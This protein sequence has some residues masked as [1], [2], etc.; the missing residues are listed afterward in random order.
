MVRFTGGALHLHR[1]AEQDL[2][3]F[4]RYGAQPT[5]PLDCSGFRS[6]RAAWARGDLRLL[7]PMAGLQAR[8]P[9]VVMEASFLNLT[10]H[11]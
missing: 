6:V 5:K 4:G 3:A 10:F 1:H 7:N 9:N 8:R 11:R 2:S